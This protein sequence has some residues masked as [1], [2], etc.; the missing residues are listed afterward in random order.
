MAGIEIE[1]KYIILLPDVDVLRGEEG[2]TS[3]VITQIYLDSPAGVTHR[4]RRREYEG[5][6]SFTETRKTRIDK[7]SVVED[8]RD[9]SE[10]EYLALSAK[11]RLGTHPV[12]KTRYTF[13]S[14]GHTVEIDVYPEWKRTCI[15]E[16]EL[17]D[18]EETVEYPSFIHIVREVTGSF[19]YSNASMAKCFPREEAVKP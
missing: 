17:K 6:V 9:I 13:L 12:E 15:M 16:T 1:R 7:M 14:G 4:V 19:E 5:A 11:I 18:R 10:E 2:F 3:S 8:E